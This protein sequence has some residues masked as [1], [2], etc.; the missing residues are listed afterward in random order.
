MQ[1]IFK[2]LYKKKESFIKYAVIY[3]IYKI[4]LE[5][6]YVIGVSYWYSYLGFNYNPNIDKCILSYVIFG[7]LLFVLPR[8]LSIN[9]Q[10][11]NTFFAVNTVPM[12]S[13]YWL[14]NKQTSFTL[15]AV[16]FFLIF[17]K[18]SK[19]HAKP[20]VIRID[21]GHLKYNGIITAFFVIFVLSCFYMGVKRGGIDARS[22]SFSTIYELRAEGNGMNGLEAYLSNWCTKSLFPMLTIY[23]IYIKKY[24]RTFICMLCQIFMY[25]CYG[26]KAYLL[27]AILTL[28]IYYIGK[29]SFNKHKESNIRNLFVFIIGLVPCCLTTIKGLV[30]TIC[31]GI[32]NTYAMRMLYEPARIEHGYFEFFS[33]NNKLFFSEGLIGKLFGLHYPYDSAIGFVV[34][35]YLNGQE[36]VSNSNTG[37]VAD[38]YAQLGVWGILIIAV[39]AGCLIVVIKQICIHIPTYFIV[40]AFFYPV[41]MLNDNPLLTNL[42]TNGW[43]LDICLLILI[44]GALRQKN[45]TINVNEK[46]K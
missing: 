36:A 7:V 31:F 34:T 33:Q 17:N 20:L 43:I 14:A 25:L 24:F 23:Y 37:I 32:N 16:L 35:R 4:L 15:Y 19:I 38:S 18:I 29:Y 21:R 30:G 8:D 9:G 13:F 3:L 46:V 41:I 1:H 11:L 44:E 5:Y 26:Y 12:L 10:L 27:A 2:K 39:L 40:A 6:T 45:S 28:A 42:L 22:F